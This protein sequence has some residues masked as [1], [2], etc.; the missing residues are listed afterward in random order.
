MLRV[1][2]G[3][4]LVRAVYGVWPSYLGALF[5]MTHAYAV[6]LLPWWCV[7]VWCVPFHRQMHSCYLSGLS[8]SR[9]HCLVLYFSPPFTVS[10]A[11]GLGAY[12][13]IL[14]DVSCVIRLCAC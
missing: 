13:L 9:T 7:R 11:A 3:G 6:W 2:A 12:C 4:D 5:V 10:A 14:R 8:S 1:L